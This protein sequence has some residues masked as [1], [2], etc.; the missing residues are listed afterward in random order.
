MTVGIQLSA[1]HSILKKVNS[2]DE[3]TLSVNESEDESHFFVVSTLLF[4]FN[5]LDC[6]IF[7]WSVESGEVQNWADNDYQSWKS[8]S[9]RQRLPLW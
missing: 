1:L 4:R 8:R 9:S 7:P 3:V 6:E 2:D 5:F